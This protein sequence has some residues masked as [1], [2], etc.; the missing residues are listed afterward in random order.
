MTIINTQ[1]SFLQQSLALRKN[2]AQKTQTKNKFKDNF[3]YFTF[4]LV[5]V[6][7]VFGMKDLPHHIKA[8]K[9]YKN[10]LSS[11]KNQYVE[12]SIRKFKNNNLCEEPMAEHNK[13]EQTIAYIDSV[14]KNTGK[15]KIE[16]ADKVVQKQTK[17]HN[18]D[19]VG[20]AKYFLVE[21][22]LLI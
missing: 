10:T 6:A 2:N 17:N 16:V 8:N 13:R 1:N 5:A 19:L 11:L 14:S 18:N 3:K 21:L 15:I 12:N 7:L 4:G 22:I 20:D 9:K